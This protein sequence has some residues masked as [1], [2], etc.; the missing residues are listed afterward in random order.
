VPLLAASALGDQGSDATGRVIVFVQPGA[1]AVAR[2]FKADYLPEIFH[3][4]RE[5]GCE[6]DVR[7]I[8]DGAPAEVTA[9]PAIVFQNHLGRSFYYGRYTTLDR[10]H[11]F[12][13]TSSIAPQAQR[14]TMR[15]DM[16]VIRLGRAQIALRIKI[17][18]VS[19]TPPAGYDPTEFQRDAASW[20]IDALQR[21]KLREKIQLQRTD[22]TYY[23]DFNPW[24]AEDGT[25][26]LS[27]ELYSQ[28]HCKK[29]VYRKTDPPW[30]GPWEHRAEL[31]QQAARE[32]EKQVIA[33]LAD[34]ES[35]D[36]LNPVPSTVRQRDWDAMGLALPPP[37]EQNS[38]VVAIGELTREWTLVHPSEQSESMLVFQFPAPLDG[39]AG[40]VRSLK[41]EWRLADG[42]FL[43]GASGWIEADPR[44]VSM[45]EPDLDD[46]LQSST[47]LHTDK[48]GSSR[49]ELREASGD[50]QPLVPGI[51]TKA[52]LR[53]VFTLK[54]VSIPLTLTASF[55]PVHD[56]HGNSQLIMSGEFTIPLAPFDL[57]GPDPSQEASK[58][59]DFSF[60]FSFASVNN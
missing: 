5:M 16:P 38:Q 15:E 27:V 47:F 11:S 45:G 32:L 7:D 26:F 29:P 6:W 40:E 33:S 3:I 41:G 55:S 56:K 53:G 8:A 25:L 57:D 18:P 13:R 59:L 30:T 49:F 37:P 60:R 43:E 54:G 17:A 51:T 50:G 39:Y 24:R 22:R 31:F 36:G 4:A 1:S 44:S 14:N 12:I 20:V 46:A 9:T 48:V 21:A 2:S 42:F 58:R 19:G 35:G 28:Y 52:E 34:T 23:L 10:V